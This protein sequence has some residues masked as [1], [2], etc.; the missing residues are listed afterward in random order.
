MIGRTNVGGSG[1]GR[2]S[3][4][5]FYGGKNEVITYTG[6]ENGAVTLDESGTGTAALKN[7]LYVFTAGISELKLTKSFYADTTVRMRP[8]RFIYWYG[9][10]NGTITKYDSYGTLRFGDNTFT[11]VAGGENEWCACQSDIDCSQDTKLS[12]LCSVVD[13]TTYSDLLY[14]TYKN[15]TSGEHTSIKANQTVSLTY[16]Y[17][18]NKK[19][20][21]AVF[22][23]NW[24]GRK[25]T[26]KEWYLGNRDAA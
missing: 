17:K 8:E 13:S 18:A 15:N 20:M 1:G 6:A 3:T 21:L 4:I 26:V 22:N 5:T 7:G 12:T 16:A 24:T 25:I 19:P 10:I 2:K 23:G 9:V 11:F 14:S